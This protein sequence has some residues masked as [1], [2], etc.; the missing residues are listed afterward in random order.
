[1]DISSQNAPAIRLDFTKKTGWGTFLKKYVAVT[2][3]R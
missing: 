1:M 3:S 2:R